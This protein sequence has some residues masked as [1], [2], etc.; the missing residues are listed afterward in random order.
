VVAGRE[1]REEAAAEEVVDREDREEAGEV[2]AG[3][4]DSGIRVTCYRNRGHTF[5]E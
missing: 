1:D 2:A 4:E 5:D 3:M